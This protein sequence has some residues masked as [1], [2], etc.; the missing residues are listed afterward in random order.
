MRTQ[1]SEPQINAHSAQSVGYNR[2]VLLK[3]VGY[4]RHF[5]CYIKKLL[6]TTAS[7]AFNA[8]LFAYQTLAIDRMFLLVTQNKFFGCVGIAVDA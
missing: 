3:S 6:E 1:F 2:Q 4:N 7:A 5:S 8:S